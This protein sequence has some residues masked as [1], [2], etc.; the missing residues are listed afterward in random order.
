MK[1]WL[2]K[3]EPESFS[4]DDLA[5]MPGKTTFW[6]GVRNY[7]ARNFMR[8]MEPGDQVFFYHS[9]ADPPSIVGIA[10]VVKKAYPDPTALDPRNHHYY[11]KSTPA[12]PIWEMVDIRLIR[13][14]DQ[15]LSLD[16]LRDVPGLEKMEL[17]RKGSRLS[18]QPVKPQEWKIILR[19]A[20]KD[21]R[22]NI[23]K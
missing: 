16:R 9:N 8:E 1:H 23:K 17:L 14:F 5:K 15:A 7:Q 22:K 18:V 20:E 13:K 6:D 12:N 2:M 10:E 3:S 4:I 19:I 11:P 21:S